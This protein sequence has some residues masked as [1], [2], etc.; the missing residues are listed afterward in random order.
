MIYSVGTGPLHL[1]ER[2]SSSSHARQCYL[3]ADCHLSRLLKAFSPL[4]SKLQENTE[5]LN[6]LSEGIFLRLLQRKYASLP[7]TPISNLGVSLQRAL[8]GPWLHSCCWNTS[9][10][11][12]IVNW[13][14]SHS[15]FTNIRLQVYHELRGINSVL[16]HFENVSMQT[17]CNSISVNLCVVWDLFSFGCSLLSPGPRRLVLT[18]ATCLNQIEMG[19]CEVSARKLFLLVA[20][21]KLRLAGLF[22]GGF[23][24]IVL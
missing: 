1:A 15:S 24:I 2:W 6:C 21:S 7:A 23:W 14:K 17:S 20:H 19:F 18:H 4:L 13:K 12:S 9:V 8:R 11:V 22:P 10:S 16:F 5:G 3:P